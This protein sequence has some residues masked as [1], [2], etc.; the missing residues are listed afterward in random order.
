LLKNAVPIRLRG[1]ARMLLTDALMLREKR[2][3]KQLSQAGGGLRLHLGCGGVRKEGWVNVDLLG[4][5]VDVAWDLSKPLPFDDG[6]VDAVF[7]EHLLEHLP[8]QSGIGFSKECFR[9]VRPGGIVRVGVPDAGR[10]LASYLDPSDDY[11]DRLHPGR[12]TRLLAAQELFYWHR[13]LTMYD[14]ETLGL[15]LEAS[16]LEQIKE[17]EFGDS[18]LPSAPD[19]QT[20]RENTLYLEGRRPL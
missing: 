19:T 20:R 14:A 7:H 9:V 4:D 12:P 15:V 2:K 3:A 5:P 16:G 10:L 8:L 13:H 6:S 1:T 17:R 18:D 11:L